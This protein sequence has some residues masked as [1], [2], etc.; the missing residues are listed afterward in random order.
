MLSV[1]LGPF[2]SSLDRIL[3][4]FA[5]MVALA[6]GA[7][8]GRRRNVAVGG[9][10][11]NVVLLGALGARIGFVLRYFEQYRQDWLGILDIRDE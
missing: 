3:L 5:V 10:L 2:A 11:L 8:L 6:V 7:L 9:A 4:L 1:H